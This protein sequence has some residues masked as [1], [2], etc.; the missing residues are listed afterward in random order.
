ML[1]DRAEALELLET[2]LGNIN[3]IRHCLASEA[4]L[5]AL[6]EDRG[7]DPDLWGITGLLH[8]IDYELTSNDPVKH[9]MVAAEMLADYLPS[10]SI[11]AIQSHNAL[12]TGIERA[13]DFDHLLAAGESITGLIVAVALV[14]PD[15]KLAS[16]KT[17][18]VLKRMNMSAFARSVPRDTIRECS[19]AGYDLDVFV[20]LAL[21]AMKGIAENIGL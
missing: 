7:E 10:E 6:A 13:S 11:H 3:L 2:H 12:H 16:V 19:K 14:Y 21:D 17:K 20:A 9:G 8:D 18:S 4:V 5:R 1:T 15:R